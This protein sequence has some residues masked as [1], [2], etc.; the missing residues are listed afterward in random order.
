MEIEIKI[1]KQ[2]TG[3]KSSNDDEILESRQVIITTEITTKITTKI[4]TPEIITPIT[5]T[6]LKQKSAR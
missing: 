5:T 2:M 3:E 6:Y 1:G 4:I